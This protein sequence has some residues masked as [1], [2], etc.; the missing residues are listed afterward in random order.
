MPT[1]HVQGIPPGADVYADDGAPHVSP[2]SETGRAPTRPPAA[3]ADDIQR[4]GSAT[5]IRLHLHT[6][7]A[8]T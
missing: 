5:P 7:G 1:V 8:Y 3:V 6:I 4:S 2:Y